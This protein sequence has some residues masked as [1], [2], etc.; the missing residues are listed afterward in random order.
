MTTEIAFAACS[1]VRSPNRPAAHERKSRSAG[2]RRKGVRAAIRRNPAGGTRRS[3][4][5]ARK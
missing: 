1:A 4:S 3:R 2:A 5:S